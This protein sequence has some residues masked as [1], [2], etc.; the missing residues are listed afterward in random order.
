MKKK[1][2]VD[3]VKRDGFNQLKKEKARDREREGK[4]ERERGGKKNFKGY[5]QCYQMLLYSLI[6]SEVNIKPKYMWHPSRA[7]LDQYQETK[8]KK[9]C[10]Q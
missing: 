10:T 9:N 1:R 7:K 5:L 2:E 4:R 3:G 6:S 8:M